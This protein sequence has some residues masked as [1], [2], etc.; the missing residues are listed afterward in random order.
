MIDDVQG[1]WALALNGDRQGVLFFVAVYAF[2]VCFYSFVRQLMTRQWPCVRGTLL[3]ASVQTFGGPEALASN[4]DYKV[5][6]RYEYVV[7]GQTYC[8]TRVSPWIIVASHNARFVL[9]QQ[10]SK[11]HRHEDGTVDVFYNPKKPGKSYLVRPGVGGMMV[12]L[13]F[14]VVP[15]IYYWYAFHA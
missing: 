2:V 4:R 7:S 10:L 14:A 11:I 6:S 8:G 3:D 12:T 15:F 5:D 9:Q 13:A 1:M